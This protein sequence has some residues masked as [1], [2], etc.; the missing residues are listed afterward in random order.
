MYNKKLFS[1]F[2][3]IPRYIWPARILYKAPCPRTQPIFVDCTTSESSLLFPWESI[4]HTGRCTG[5]LCPSTR[6]GPFWHSATLRRTY[7]WNNECNSLRNRLDRFQVYAYSQVFDIR[8]IFPVFASLLQKENAQ[9]SPSASW[10]ALTKGH[11]NNLLC[12]APAA[13][14]GFR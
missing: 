10:Y 4:A 2:R 8:I 9:K 7:A 5:T 13:A 11:S 1:L 3:F 6:G 14:T 12:S